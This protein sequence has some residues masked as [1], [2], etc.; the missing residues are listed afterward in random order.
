[1]LEQSSAT[2]DSSTAVNNAR[3]EA[4]PRVAVSQQNYKLVVGRQLN[5]RGGARARGGL[6]VEAAAGL[7]GGL[8]QLRLDM[9]VLGLGG[10]GGA[11]DAGRAAAARGGTDARAG[12]LLADLRLD[13]LGALALVVLGLARGV[14][15]DLGDDLGLDSLNLGASR[16][17]AHLAAL[18]LL[19]AAARGRGRRGGGLGALVSGALGVGSRGLAV[20]GQ[21][22]LTLG[23]VAGGV[24]GGLQHSRGRVSS[25]DDLRHD[26]EG[27]ESKSNTHG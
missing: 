9:E 10:D 7:D 1:M 24:L 5:E 21:D 17:G 22:G 27:D 18:D 19:R 23:G 6:G 25:E 3:H 14:A 12:V 15:L 26:D 11:D 13:V 20:L 16:H 8:L 2:S 4:A